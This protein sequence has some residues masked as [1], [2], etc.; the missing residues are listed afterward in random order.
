MTHKKIGRPRKPEKEKR[1]KF[2]CLNCTEA[3]YNAIVEKANQFKI[4]K[5]TLI[6]M[7]IEQLTMIKQ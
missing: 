6:R 4:R 3:E 5:S 1:N 7:A 2:I